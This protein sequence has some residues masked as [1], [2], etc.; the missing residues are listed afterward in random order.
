LRSLFDFVLCAVQGWTAGWAS[1][2][3]FEWHRYKD[4]NI[5]SM[6]ELQSLNF[7]ELSATLSAVLDFPAGQILGFA[8][9]S[10]PSREGLRED[11]GSSG[12]SEVEI[13]LRGKQCTAFIRLQPVVVNMS[14]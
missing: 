6:I 10:E 1:I 11:G 8:P 14:S 9:C 4:R 5:C 13:F 2:L 12:D 7:N 3:K